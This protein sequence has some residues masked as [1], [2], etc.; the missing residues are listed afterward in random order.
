[1]HIEFPA[2][3]FRNVML[4]FGDNMR[5]KTSLLNAIRWGFY[6]RA[7]GRHSQTIGPQEIINK[8]AALE[9]D[10]TFEV[11]IKFEANDH[12][13]DLRRR[14]EKRAIVSVPQRPEDYQI[15]VHLSEDGIPV[16]GDMIDAKINNIAPEQVSVLS[17]RR[18]VAPGI[19]DP[20]DRGQHARPA[21]QRSHRASAWRACLDKRPR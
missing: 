8:E 18:R 11:R 19:R 15:Q 2:D 17:L 14:A 16:Q 21:D 7:V 3:G 1:M 6:G 9:A 10:W 12:S 4:V 20:P 5:G 13:Y